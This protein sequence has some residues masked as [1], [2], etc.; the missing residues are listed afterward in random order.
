MSIPWVI[1]HLSI[2]LTPAPRAAPD[3][4][5][6]CP[7]CAGQDGAHLFS[8][9][10]VL[11]DAE[12]LL[13]HLIG[14]PPPPRT[15]A[16]LFMGGESS[17]EEEL[18]RAVCRHSGL[19]APRDL[20]EIPET[21]CVQWMSARSLAGEPSLL[22]ALLRQRLSPVDH[23]LVSHTWRLRAE[24]GAWIAEL[25]V[26]GIR[27]EAEFQHPL[28]LRETDLYVIYPRAIGGLPFE[29]VLLEWV[30]AI[31][32]GGIQPALF[33]TAEIRSPPRPSEQ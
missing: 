30:R 7:S 6:L 16:Y 17:A 5:S 12:A 2:L 33:G 27:A 26:A 24:A 32:K 3:P 4:L 20:E 9:E 21:S 10:E 13:Q 8:E 28:R 25:R 15:S 22:F 19:L 11:A 14:T 23:E 18:E 31:E 29:D 1:L